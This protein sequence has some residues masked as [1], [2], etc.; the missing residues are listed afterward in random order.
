MYICK[1]TLHTLYIHISQFRFSL[2][3]M[4]V[5]YLTVWKTTASHAVETLC[6]VLA[7]ECVH[8][9]LCKGMKAATATEQQIFKFRDY[10][11]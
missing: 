3:L 4:H 10:L 8:K 9:C 6:V 11:T 1:F 2:G 7:R 5:N